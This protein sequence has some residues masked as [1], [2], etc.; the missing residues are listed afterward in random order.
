MI[1]SSSAT[2]T[3]INCTFSGNSSDDFGG[4]VNVSYDA[5]LQLVGCV[6]WDNLA[7]DGDEIHIGYPGGE[8]GTMI[9]SNSDVG[10]G[11]AG[12]TIDGGTLNWGT[13]NIDADPLFVDAVAGNFRLSPGSLCIDSGAN[14]AN[15]TTTDLGGN[16]RFVDDPDTP[17]CPQA[18]G[19]CG[20]P[21][22][23]D[24]GAYEFQPCPWDC[25]NPGDG[26]VGIS[27]FLLLLAQ[28]GGPGTCDFDG[29]GVG[30]TDFLEL[31]ANWGPCP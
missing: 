27:D 11:E 22:V 20:D 6:L 3:L 19:Q 15:A 30:I 12:V 10:G 17:D 29:G 4:A 16:P 9:V 8:S 21:P 24:M 31:L 26:F 13:G 2:A 23:V 25:A 18:P 7:L 14:N 1:V 5:D 28:W